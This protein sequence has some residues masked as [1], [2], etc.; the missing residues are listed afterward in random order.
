MSTRAGWWASS[1][2]FLAPPS[3]PIR[4]SAVFHPLTCPT[5]SSSSPSLQYV[6]L[7]QQRRPPQPQD[8]HSEQIR[9]SN[10]Q[11]RK[12]RLNL[13]RC[14]QQQDHHNDPTGDEGEAQPED[15]ADER[16]ARALLAF[17]FQ[18]RVTAKSNML[19]RCSFASV[20][21]TLIFWAYQLSHRNDL[22]NRFS[23]SYP[24]TKAV[25]AFC[26]PLTPNFAYGGP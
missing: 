25:M 24:E 19:A 21:S 4:K 8:Q 16:A 5:A 9:R 20:I 6:K 22:E 14:L 10:H 13:M 3:L 11:L 23:T 7:Q 26:W 15:P 12:A 2:C 18:P 1:S 17:F